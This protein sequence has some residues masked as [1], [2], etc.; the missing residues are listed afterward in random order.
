MVLS[1]KIQGNL[2]ANQS[3]NMGETQTLG[4]GGQARRKEPGLRCLGVLA[5]AGQKL[6]KLRGVLRRERLDLQAKPPSRKDMPDHAVC[7]NLP[8]LYQKM[9]PHQ[10]AFLLSG[11]GFQD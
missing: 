5:Q 9:E 2:V 1:G 4:V 11:M 6:S 10:I 8:F 3:E 7:A